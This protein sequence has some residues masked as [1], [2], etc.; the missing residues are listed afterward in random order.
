[1]RG[2]KLWRAGFE[3]TAGGILVLGTFSVAN[4]LGDALAPDLLVLLVLCALALL[5]VRRRYPLASGLGLAA[6][7]GVVPAVGLLTGIAAYTATR[8]LTVARRRTVLLLAGSVLAIVSC[9]L[10]APYTGVGPPIFGVA[11]G[12]VLAATTVLVPG[13]VGAAA[14]QQDRLLLALRERTAAAEEAERQAD[15]AS[16]IHERSRIAAEMHDLVGHRLSL[17]SLHAGGLELALREQAPD[18]QGEAALVRGATR[19]AMRELREVLG[20]LGP[21]GRDTGTDALTDA[22]GTRADIEALVEESR[23]GGVLVDLTWSGP[24]LD[25]REARVRR[26][27]HRVVRESLTN[28]HRYAAGARV[29]VTVTHDEQRVRITVRNGVPPAGAAPPAARDAERIGTGRGLTGLRERVALLGGTLAAGPTPPGGFEVAADLPAEPETVPE[30][31][32]PAEPAYAHAP[33]A[34]SGRGL[35][36]MQRRLADAATGLLGLAGVGVM[37]LFGMVLVDQARPGQNYEPPADPRLGMSRDEVQAALYGEGDEARA[38]AFGREP[39]RPKSATSCMYPFTGNDPKHREEGEMELVRYCFT[40][41]KLTAI[42]RFTVP[43]VTEP[44]DT[45]SPTAPTTSTEP[46][47]QQP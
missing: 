29:D 38:A 34:A 23:G 37:M 19:D 46:Q 47:E 4:S 26:A 5:V 28:V 13:L 27:V 44:T 11:L 9:G 40:G 2:R 31:D 8:Q 6:L 30:T 42:D 15:S 25:R 21:L 45:P 20:V 36:G 18:L 10:T 1:M 41:D 33:E 39:P 17:I 3:A 35:P 14:G 32:A 43:L 12:A 22:T 16:R 7:M 24:D